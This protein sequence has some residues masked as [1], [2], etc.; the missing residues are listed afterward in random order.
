MLD[1]TSLHF[2]SIS[3]SFHTCHIYIHHS[4]LYRCLLHILPSLSVFYTYIYI[5]I[6]QLSYNHRYIIYHSILYCCHLYL[7]FIY[8]YISVSTSLYTITDILYII[9]S[10][11]VA[12]FVF[13]IIFCN[14]FICLSYTFILQLVTLQH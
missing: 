6:H 14:M 1:F 10:C 4:I 9:P 8:I 2:I 11:I 7:S 3:T 13:F 12:F 5:C